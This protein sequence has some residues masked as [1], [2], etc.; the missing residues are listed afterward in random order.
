VREFQPRAVVMDPISNLISG[1]TLGAASS[2]MVRLIDFL[3]AQ[4]ITAFFTSL[5]SEEHGLEQTEIG[6]SS[7]V[8]TWLLLRDVEIRGERS[9][10]LYVLKSRGM[11][12]SRQVREFVLTSR[13]PELRDPVSDVGANGAAPARKKRVRT[14]A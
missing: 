6:V 13:G 4:G 11:A 3:K 7:L 14:P 10:G 5:T 8:D 2:M 1:G 9:H 12:H